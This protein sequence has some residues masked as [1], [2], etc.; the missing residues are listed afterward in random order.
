MISKK[1][2][3]IGAFLV[4]GI[5]LLLIT[6]RVT[7][8]LKNYTISSTSMEPNL[9]KGSSVLVSNIGEPDIGD[10]IVFKHT[11]S[12]IKNNYW[13]FRLVGKENDT[14]EI[15]NGIF[16]RN[17]KNIDK[18]I[19]LAYNYKIS[20]EEYRKLKKDKKIIDAQWVR[21]ISADTFAA[22]LSENTAK[23]RKLTKQRLITTSKYVNP[24]IKEQYGKNWNK[25][26]F[27]PLIVPQGKLFVL[28]DNRDNSYDSRYIG[29]IDKNDV[30][31]VVLLNW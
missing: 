15:R 20:P 30:V 22:H 13:V 27:G 8:V 9:K 2:S 7:G 3:I 14:I 10:F 23:S 5:I 12:I 25:D 17:G 18:E 28:G 4:I 6:V 16:Y 26:N 21:S 31:G 1:S 19:T 11:D 24:E 29:L